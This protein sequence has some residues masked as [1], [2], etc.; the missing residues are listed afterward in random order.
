MEQIFNKYDDYII[1]TQYK[2]YEPLSEINFNRDGGIIT[3]EIEGSDS[4]LNV[5]NAK[6]I[7]SGKYLKADDTE[8]TPKSNVK[9]DDN[10]VG[11][12]FSQIEVT[13]NGS[14]IDQIENVGRSSIIKGCISYSLDG[15][16]PTMSSGFESRFEG[17]GNFE[18]M[19]NLS[20]LCLGFFKDI[21]YPIFKGGI[22][23]HFKRANNNDALFRW[24]SKPEDTPG[25]G[26]VNIV[27]FKIKVPLVE[28]QEMYKLQLINEL[29]KLSQENNYKLNFK[30]WQCIDETNLSG[31]TFKRNIASTYRNIHNPLFA[32][33]GFQTKGLETQL[34]KASVFDHCNV[35]N[36]WLEI[37]GQ[38]YPQESLN[39]DWKNGKFILAYDMHM[40]YKKTFHKTHQEL[41]LMYLTPTSFRDAR[42]LY[43]LNLTR[44][45][46]SVSGNRNNI[47]LNIEFNEDVPN[48]TIC[49]I[50]LVSTS[51]F[52]YDIVHNTIRKNI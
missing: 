13:K 6:Y 39:L 52:T 32:I 23:I 30:S 36:I 19:G 3:F 41:P 11:F 4:F 29:T 35:K 20:N 16:G 8:Y 1:R 43:V 17:G 48:G 50:C 26:K 31:K 28:Y 25:V 18:A 51:S 22:K 27:D 45:P 10:F 44:Q 15:N 47:I 14:L 9:L 46:D 38:R 37:D 49:Y 33:V 34:R 21:R 5:K 40:S 12:L 24:G 2:T 42:T 7:I